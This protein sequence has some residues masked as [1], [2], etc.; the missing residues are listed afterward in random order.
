[1]GT[2]NITLANGQLGSTLQTSDGI[3]GM[4]LTGVSESGGYTVSTPVLVTGLDNMGTQGITETNNPFAW[5]QV[6]E[7]Y[8]EAGT[9]AQ[10]YLMLVPATMAITA[11]ADHATAD[12][13]KKL[14]EYAHGKIKVLGI[15]TDDGA[16][17]TALSST[18]TP[19]HGINEDVYTAATNMTVLAQEYFEAQKPFRAVIGGTSYDGSAASLT[20]QTAG[21]TNNRTAI[22]I[23][24]T[25]SGGAA[26]LG[27]FMGRISAIPVMRK[28]SRVRTGSLSN[29]AAFLGTAALESVAGD[30]PVIAGKGLITWTIYPNVAGYFFSGDDTLSATTDDYHFL[31]RGR[32][33]DKAHVLAYTTFVQEVDDEVPVNEDGTLDAGFCKWLSQ[34]IE[35]QLNGTMT[36]NKEVSSVKCVIDPA[37]NIL[38]TNQL[39]VVIRIVPVGYATNIEISLGFSNPAA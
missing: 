2:V 14:L 21:T 4:V 24:D 19:T 16:V 15:M 39:N 32:V 31:A 23:G 6:K 20:D 3:V 18:I 27:L 7:F 30:I 33:I 11:I 5:R 29:A 37:Q 22:L 12:G 17:A 26:C 1:M 38:S 9:G 10:L 8:D 36:A 34:Q 35:N 28:V 13:A 25:Q